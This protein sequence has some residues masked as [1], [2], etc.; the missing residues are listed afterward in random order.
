MISRTILILFI[1]SISPAI[2]ADIKDNLLDKSSGLISEFVSNL[3]PGDGTTEVSLD[4]REN[5]KPDFS[6]LGV[7]EL[8]KLENGNYFTQ[9]S[10]MN[11]EQANDER[12]IGNL[13][14]GP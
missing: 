9:F 8:K 3:I 10:L 11:T 4:L 2:S 7:R 12:F 14:Y 5:H 1:L 13:G 6:I